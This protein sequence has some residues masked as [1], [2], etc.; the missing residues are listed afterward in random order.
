MIVAAAIGVVLVVLACMR[1]A[2]HFTYY[3][4]GPDGE[5]TMTRAIAHRVWRASRRARGARRG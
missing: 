1:Y 3:R 5:R 4:G 2:L